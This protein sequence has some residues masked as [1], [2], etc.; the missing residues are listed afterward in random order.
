MKRMFDK[1]YKKSYRTNNVVIIR[2]FNEFV[3]NVKKSKIYEKFVKSKSNIKILCVTNVIEFE[4]NILNMKIII[5]WKISLNV[6][7]LM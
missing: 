5:L 2:C 6:K 3:S 7:A 4:M 1:F